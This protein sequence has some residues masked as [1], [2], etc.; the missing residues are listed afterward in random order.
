MLVEF[1]N[2]AAITLFKCASDD[3]GR[4][5]C[6]KRVYGFHRTCKFCGQIYPLCRK[7]FYWTY[8]VS[9]GLLIPNLILLTILYFKG[10]W[11]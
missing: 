6:G 2:E 3:H 8:L 11:P 7:G 5:E 9:I 1:P 10:H 4:L